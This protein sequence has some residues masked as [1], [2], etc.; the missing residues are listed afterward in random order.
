MFASG[1]LNVLKMLWNV[2]FSGLTL[3][4]HILIQVTLIHTLIL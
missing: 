3:D 2:K 4:T 1:S